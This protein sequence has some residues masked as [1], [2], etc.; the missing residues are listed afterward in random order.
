MSGS[1]ISWA[2]CKSAPR[3]RHVT[4]P[5]LHHSVFLQAGCPSC[6][7]T[8]SVKALKA[9]C[10]INWRIFMLC[11]T[12]NYW[13][14]S[15]LRRCW[16]GVRKSIRPVKGGV[17]VVICLKRGADCLH[18]VQ[19]MPLHPKTPSYLASFKSRLVLPFWYRLTQVVLEMRPLNESSSSSYPRRFSLQAAHPRLHRKYPLTNLFA[20]AN[21]RS[22]VMLTF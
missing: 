15:V 1:G 22:A 14:P 19:M 5:A 13:L 4:T 20:C 10:L 12:C 3:S 6:R 9:S 21:T 11:N 7:P 8:N 2:I 16:L 18:M 17:Y